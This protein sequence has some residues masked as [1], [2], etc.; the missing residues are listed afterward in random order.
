MLTSLFNFR[1]RPSLSKGLLAG[2]IGGLA[3]GLIKAAAEVIYPR[4]VEGQISPPVLLV[5]RMVEH[6]G[7][8]PLSPEQQKLAESSVHFVFSA[9]VG[10]LYGALAEYWPEATAGEGCAFALVLLG[11]THESALPAL[12]LT[13]APGRQPK[14]EQLSELATHLVFG[15]AT[16]Q[17]R[18]R[19]RAWM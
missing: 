7:G 10:A 18:A 15:F 4:R 1:R 19:V 2:A 9:A 5:S 13:E 17:L 3:G 11:A 12:G 6:S 8:P 14:Q 16:E